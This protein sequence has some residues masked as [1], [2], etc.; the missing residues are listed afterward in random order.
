LQEA[1]GG[2]QQD[3]STPKAEA[4]ISSK[5]VIET[6]CKTKRVPQDPR[7]P[8]KIVMIS[9]DLTSEE[10][11]ELLSFLDKNSDVFAW[12]TSDLMGVS[13]SII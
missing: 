4:G 10:E 3:S 13:K 1:E 12:K 8:D 11:I 7:V 6:E 5:A 2:G 9:K